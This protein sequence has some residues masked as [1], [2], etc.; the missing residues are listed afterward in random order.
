[1]IKNQ[2]VEK[3]Q[4]IYDNNSEVVYKL[5]KKLGFLY[6]NEIRLQP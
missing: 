3:F 6:A 4:V 5:K 1:M 2:Q